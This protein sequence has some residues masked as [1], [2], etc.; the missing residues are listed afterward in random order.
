MDP[1][2]NWVLVIL[3][4]ILVSIGVF[5]DVVAAIGMLRFPNFFVRL[6]AATIG[7]I[8]GAFVPLMGVALIAA[9]CDF[10]GKYRWFI[11]GAAA[12]TGVLVLML[13]PVGS[14]LLAKAAHESRA[15]VVEPKVV[16]FLEEDKAKE[17][18]EQ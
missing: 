9:G 16:D 10:L 13:A 11:A 1:V 4:E 6:H 7:A 12:V 2:T 15:A 17:G 5:F 18:G 14:H 3:G 8:G